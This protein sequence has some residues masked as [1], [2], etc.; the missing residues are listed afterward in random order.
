MSIILTII[1]FGIIVIIHEWGHMRACGV[2]VEE[3]AVGMGPKLCGFK[4]GDT[5][6]TIRALPLGGFCRMK[7]ETEGD[8]VGF[9]N[10]SVW[11]RMIICVAGPL[12]NFV[13]AIAVMMILG[14]MQSVSTT[15]IAEIVEN[16]R[17]PLPAGRVRENRGNRD[18]RDSLPVRFCSFS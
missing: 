7:D 2:F 5:L 10:V 16:S 17:E 3:F 9:L 15:Q 4:K 13:L 18:F 12:M 14:M 8:K 1:I 6:Y 11:K